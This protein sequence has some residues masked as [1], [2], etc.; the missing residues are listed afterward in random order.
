[1]SDRME[2]FPYL[3]D[4]RGTYSLWGT[5]M[6]IH[7]PMSIIPFSSGIQPVPGSE[8]GA[9]ADSIRHDS[10]RV[11]FRFLGYRSRAEDALYGPP[12]RKTEARVIRGG[13]IDIYV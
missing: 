8:K 5:I 12:G 10:P 9:L 13:V 3:H 6:T 4:S 11:G 1:M 7:P 2:P